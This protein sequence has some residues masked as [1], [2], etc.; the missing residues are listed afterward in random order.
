MKISPQKKIKKF[1][2]EENHKMASCSR[3]DWVTPIEVP[4]I[5]LNSFNRKLADSTAGVAPIRIQNPLTIS[6]ALLKAAGDHKIKLF[7]LF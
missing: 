1:T 7:K 5:K 4:S 3:I 6:E 2:V